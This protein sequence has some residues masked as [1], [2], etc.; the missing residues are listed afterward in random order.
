MPTV[1]D[2]W[3]ATRVYPEYRGFSL[4]PLKDYGYMELF[5]VI[6]TSGARRILEFGH[7]LKIHESI[8]LFDRFKGLELWGLDDDQGLA[9]FSSGEAWREE[10]ERNVVRR[11]PWVK[12]VRGLLG[13]PAGFGE[14]AA[15]YFDIVCSVSV[16]EE[17]PIESV[18]PVLEHAYRLLKPGGLLVNS[19]DIRLGDDMRFEEIVRLQRRAGF[20]IDE[21]RVQQP[22]CPW[23]AT[24]L[25]LENPLGVMIY[26]QGAQPEERRFMGNFATMMMVAQR[27]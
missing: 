21:A 12:F 25:L 15:G 16:L 22:G 7:G 23:D 27:P 20:V 10:Y 26:Y 24:Y 6:E 9:Y 1:D 14:L 13:A 19:H 2:W 5:R 3:Q 8:N 17:V 4:T 11:F 18:S